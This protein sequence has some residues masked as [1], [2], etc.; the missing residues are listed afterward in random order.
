MSSPARG[1]RIARQKSPSLVRVE[2]RNSPSRTRT[3]NKPVNRGSDGQLSAATKPNDLCNSMHVSAN[4]QALASTSERSQET[5][6]IPQPNER[7][8]RDAR[9][10]PRSSARK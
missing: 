1:A 10:T 9:N 3:Y 5:T 6:E 2:T 8:G 7:A 4:L